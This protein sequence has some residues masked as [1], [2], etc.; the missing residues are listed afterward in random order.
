[1]SNVQIEFADV[2]II[3]IINETNRSI[4]LYIVYDDSTNI[5]SNDFQ[6]TVPVQNREVSGS[7]TSPNCRSTWYSSEMSNV[8]IKFLE[9]INPSIFLVS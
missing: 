3:I 5:P 1:M 2:T 6:T 7:E 9:L 4:V 8:K